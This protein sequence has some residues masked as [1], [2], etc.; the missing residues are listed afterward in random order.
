MILRGGG[1][2]VVEEKPVLVLLCPAH[3]PCGLTLGQPQAST[4]RGQ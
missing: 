4:V 3:I 2:T 1:S